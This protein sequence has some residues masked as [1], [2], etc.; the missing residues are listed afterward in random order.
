MLSLGNN[1]SN[2]NA[3]TVVIFDASCV[4]VDRALRAIRAGFGAGLIKSLPRERC[5]VIQTVAQAA[6]ARRTAWA[7]RVDPIY[8]GI[9]ESNG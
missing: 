4:K 6:I 1:R 8:E 2:C 3:G 5:R 7:K 9:E